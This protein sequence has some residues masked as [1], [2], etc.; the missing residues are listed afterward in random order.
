MRRGHGR[1]R[2]GCHPERG[3]QS[4][5]AFG[6]GVL[7]VRRAPRRAGRQA[8]V[9]HEPHQHRLLD[10]A[11]HGPQ[12]HRGHRGDEDGAVPGRRG[13]ERRL[14][15]AGGRQGLLAARDLGHDSRQAEG[16]GRGVPRRE[17]HARGHHRAG[18][19]QR[20]AAPGDEGCG[21]DRG[22]DRRATGQR[23]DGGGARLWSRQ[24]EG[25]DDRRLRLRRRHVRH[26]DP[27]GGRGRRRG[28]VDQRRHAP[29]RRQHRPARH[30]LDSRGVQEG[31]GRRP[32]EGPDGDAA[33]EGSGGEG[34]DRAVERRRDGSQP[35]VHHGGRVRA[36]APPAE[37]DALEAR[38][39]RRGH[40]PEV[41]RSLQ[42][43]DEG[44]GRRAQGHRRGRARRRPDPHAADPEARQGA[45][46][47]GSAP[48][49][50]PRRGGRGRRGDSG[51]RP[52]G[53]RQGPAAA[54]RDAALARHRDARAA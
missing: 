54:G 39:A 14:P 9:H 20:F 40:R 33:P 17:G 3:R 1:R 4:D 47:Q 32:V 53:R 2:S 25:R 34:Q 13:V 18:V 12:V 29:G 5:D 23:A 28:Q 21:P 19:L 35:P 31:S 48:G 36:E 7:E 46:R 42:A 24:E 37:A 8:P 26:L 16:S 49:R 52:R 10:Q 27:R 45:L 38:A 22:P 44:R 50:Q 43:G 11:V 30:R 41:R 6:R 51:R 15:R